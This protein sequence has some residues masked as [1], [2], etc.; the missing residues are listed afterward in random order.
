MEDFNEQVSYLSFFKIVQPMHSL[1]QKKGGKW[2]G[3]NVHT[4]MERPELGM[5][6]IK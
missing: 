1:S 5:A 3:T 2:R 4:N 6:E